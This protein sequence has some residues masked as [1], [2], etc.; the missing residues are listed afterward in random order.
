MFDLKIHLPSFPEMKPLEISDKET[1]MQF[2]ADFLPYSDFNFTS[3]WSYDTE[4]KVRIAEL[5][6]NLVVQFSDYISGH[7]F[8][9]FI[10]TKEVLIK[11]LLL[12][13]QDSIDRTALKLVPETVIKS[14]PMLFKEY[15]I[16]EDKDN[17]DYI[18]STEEI[19]SL[20][21]NKYG[22][23]RN[24]VNRFLR[25]HSEFETRE[26]DL[27]NK[28]AVKDIFRLFEHWAKKKNASPEET[29]TEYTAIKRLLQIVNLLNISVIG[30]Y[31]DNRLIAFSINELG[32]DSY[33]TIHFEKADTD[34]IGLYQYLKHLTAQK[35]Q[36]KGYKYINYEQDL[37]IDGLRQAKESWQ[38]VHYLKKYTI[39][40]KS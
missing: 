37:G 35:L 40:N 12:H 6:G 16:S 34:F 10:C 7:P 11:V 2:T 17:H 31:K 24:F 21:G 23:K 1:I 20:A 30:I 8:Y 3:L 22:P 36:E 14:Q 39:S 9:S 18:L 32:H 5:N 15:D 13:A 28:K 27:I 33:G 4:N 19:G 38:P 25:L 26:L 29:K